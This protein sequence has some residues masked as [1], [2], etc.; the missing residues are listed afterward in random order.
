MC[1]RVCIDDKRG[2]EQKG[3]LR[4]VNVSS[5]V[6]IEYIICSSVG[7]YRT[8]SSVGTHRSC[9]SVGTHRICSSLGTYRICSSV[10]T[11]RICSSVGTHRICSSVGFT[12]KRCSQNVSGDQ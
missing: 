3:A 10:G 4:A 8:C 2:T 11:Y 1:V 6:L 9:S 5:P 12:D 7:T